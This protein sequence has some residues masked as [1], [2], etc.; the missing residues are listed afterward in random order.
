MERINPLIDS[1]ITYLVLITHKLSISR[2][3]RYTVTLNHKKGYTS[4]KRIIDVIEKVQLTE[5]YLG[6]I[7]H[8]VSGVNP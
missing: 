1:Y 7:A 4:T 6:E 8:I 2:C 3:T 5:E